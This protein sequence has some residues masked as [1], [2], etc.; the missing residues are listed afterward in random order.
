MAFLN[1]KENKQTIANT[2][3]QTSLSLGQMQNNREKT[4]FDTKMKR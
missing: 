3:L 2:Y 1:N 4:L